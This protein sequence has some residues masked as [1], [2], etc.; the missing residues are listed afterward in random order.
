MIEDLNY[1]VDDANAINDLLIESLGFPNENI[2]LLLNET[3]TRENI[4]KALRSISI[5]A[6]PRDRILI[7][8]AGHGKTELLATY[9]P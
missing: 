7:Y 6:Q 5:K 1:A 8:F 9:S 2:H 3:A 4:R